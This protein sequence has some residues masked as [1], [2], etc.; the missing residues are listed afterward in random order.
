MN[1]SGI[2]SKSWM[3]YTQSQGLVLFKTLYTSRRSPWE[4][5]HESFVCQVGINYNKIPFLFQY[6]HL[7]YIHESDCI[8]HVSCNCKMLRYKVVHVSNFLGSTY[9]WKLVSCF[10]YHSVYQRNI[11]MYH[12]NFQDMFWRVRGKLVSRTDTKFRF[13]DTCIWNTKQ[14]QKKEDVSQ[15]WY[16]ADPCWFTKKILRGYGPIPREKWPP[17]IWELGT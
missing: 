5:I 14:H 12:S 4:S 17:T 11:S 10:L 7:K 1:P 13:C 3:W 15:F 2:R 16:M 9:S 8:I 6:Q